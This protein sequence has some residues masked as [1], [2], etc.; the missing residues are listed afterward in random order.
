MPLHGELAVRLLD[1]V[2]G[3]VPVYAKHFVVI[4]F[5]HLPRASALQMQTAGMNGA[6]RAFDSG[7]TEP[8]R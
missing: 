5:C 7:Q 2:V 8:A 6:L 3:S 4:A 1:V